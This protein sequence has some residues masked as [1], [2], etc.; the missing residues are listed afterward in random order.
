MTAP[1]G[2]PT[3]VRPRSTV[4][5]LVVDPT[6]GLDVSETRTDTP[7]GS[8][9]ASDNF[10]MREGGLEPRPMLKTR[11][12]SPRPVA[13]RILG[14][15]EVVDVNGTRYA[16]VSGTTL[17][18]F[19]AGNDWTV[20]TYES[21]FDV[22][23]APN[24]SSND[25]WDFAQIYY[26][27]NDENIAVGG[28]TGRQ[29]L[30]CWQPASDKVS[31]LTGAPRARHV[32][33]FDNYL[34]AANITDGTN[35]FIQR[36]QWSDRGSASSWTGGL[37][38]F[39][40][41]L[42]AKGGITRLLPLENRIAVF[43]ENETWQ[44]FAGNF[45]FVFRF[46]PLDT[47]V[48]CPYG[49]TAA[50]TPRGIMFLGRDYQV[51][52]LPHAGG[53]PTPIGQRLHREVRTTID[54]PNRAWATYDHTL[55]QY[56]LYY[57]VKSGSGLPQRA[58]YLNID[59]GAWQP[60]SFDSAGGALSL[61]C[62]FEAHVPSSAT[63]WGGLQAS[64]VTWGALNLSWAELGGFTEDRAV[65]IGSSAGTIYNLD[66]DATSD[67]GTAVPCIWDSTALNGSLPIAQKTATGFAVDYQA[68]S[69]SSM[70]VRFSQTQG[71][72][73][74]TGTRVALPASSTLSQAEAHMYI[75]ARYPTFRVEVENH[76]PRLHRFHVTMREGGR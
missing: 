27:Q 41:L 28:H 32:A 22:D 9:P 6:I 74:E 1:F 66:S 75:P 71:A 5:T 49:W 46:L 37:S 43:F 44:G 56:Q 58:V 10:I 12:D 15:A 14:G 45:P 4:S 59:S 72:G 2:I 16:L 18:A 53:P 65:H 70:T 8:T 73:F 40:D 34:L 31:S 61:T 30:Y 68:T 62:G 63:T 52:L 25:H 69:A 20:L 3:E 51:Y 33:A 36:I 47:G 11:G 29:P 19:Y 17:W 35:N 50:T 64:G 48:G 38:G 60:Q 55:G 24:A 21:A 54:E 26:D 76:R 7:L 67:D 42:A 23:I 57:P 39:E 13:S